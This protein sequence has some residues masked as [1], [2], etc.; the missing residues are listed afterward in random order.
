MWL[1]TAAKRKLRENLIIVFSG[2]RRVKK[3]EITS[4]WPEK[5]QL[6]GGTF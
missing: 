6:L 1:Y 4:M 5:C 2:P 3:E